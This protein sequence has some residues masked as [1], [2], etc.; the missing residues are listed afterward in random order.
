MKTA[1]ETLNATISEYNKTVSQIFAFRF[2]SSETKMF[3]DMMEEYKDQHV[4]PLVEQ[5]NELRD[6]LLKIRDRHIKNPI[7]YNII[8]KAVNNE[9]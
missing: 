4:K 3:T 7:T 2:N 9:K 1:E 5:N 6:T 8:T